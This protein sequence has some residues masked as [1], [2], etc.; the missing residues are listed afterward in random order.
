MTELKKY[1]PYLLVA[2][3]CFSLGR[4]TLKEKIVQVPVTVSV[5]AIENV[6]LGA[7]VSKVSYDSLKKKYEWVKAHPWGEIKWDGI[8]HRVGGSDWSETSPY[9]GPSAS[10]SAQP[11]SIDVWSSQEMDT[12]LS[13]RSYIV[14]DGDTTRQEASAEVSLKLEF[15]GEPVNEFNIKKLYIPPFVVNVPYKQQIIDQSNKFSVFLTT[16]NHLTSGIMLGYGNFMVGYE[17]SPIYK[18]SEFRASFRVL[19]F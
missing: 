12:T 11:D 4:Y 5:P 16:G 14:Q 7:T 17:I 10:D 3:A 15:V 6:H 13:I 9:W 18:Q 2:I 1:L 8:T 19:D